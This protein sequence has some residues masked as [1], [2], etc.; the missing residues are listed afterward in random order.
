M[1]AHTAETLIRCYRPGKPADGRTQKA[2]KFAEQDPEL[3]KK[4]SE[5][6]QFDGE[7]VDVIHYIH[8][9]DD[10]RAKLSDSGAKPDEKTRL[11]RQAINPAI[12]TALM[13]VLLL[14]GVIVFMVMERMEKFP[15]R[16]SVEELL[17]TAA[18]MTG[19]ELETVALSTS[20]IGDWFYMKNYDGFEAPP[21]LASQSIVGARVFHYGGHSVAQ[22][23]VGTPEQMRC[24]L[25]EFQASNFGVQL[26][27]DGDWLVMDHEQ[28]VGAVRQRGDH[29]F[30]IA[31][32]GTKAEMR[33]FLRSLPAKK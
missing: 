7:I 16:E 17:G 15:G 4:L 8:P 5:Q 20:Q 14:V 30:L 24:L 22:I 18:K 3:G 10:L 6:I 2:V 29:C 9:P 12:L 25:Y 32:R 1:N 21:E 31:F 11:R 19:T 28:W 27:P 26:P 13:G 23:A 33:D